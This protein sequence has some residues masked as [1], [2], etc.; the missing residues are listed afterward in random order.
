[1]KTS[2][3]GRRAINNLVHA[4]LSIEQFV[5]HRG[6]CSFIDDA[7]GATCSCGLESAQDAAN[8]AHVAVVD[9]FPDAVK[10]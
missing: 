5:D 2:A 1:M 4:L 10:P 7:A 8:K 6:G 3:S 9:Q